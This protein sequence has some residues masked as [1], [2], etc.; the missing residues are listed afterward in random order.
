MS[1]V[2]GSNRIDSF[3]LS[4]S[5]FVINYVFHELTWGRLTCTVIMSYYIKN[6]IS[7]QADQ[8]CKG[9]MKENVSTNY[10][11]KETM[12]FTVS[13]EWLKK[14]MEECITK[15]I[16]D[17]QQQSTIQN[18]QKNRSNPSITTSNPT[19]VSSMG[20]TPTR[21]GSGTS[22]ST[23][24]LEG[25][26]VN[27]LHP[28]DMLLSWWMNTSGADIGM[29]PHH[30]RNKLT[31]LSECDAGNYSTPIPYTKDD[32]RTPHQIKE[33]IKRG[34]R[35][36]AS[37]STT[38]ETTSKLPEITTGYTFALGIDWEQHVSK[39]YWKTSKDDTKIVSSIN[40]DDNN[41]DNDDDNDSIEEDFHVPYFTE[42]DIAVIP[43]RMNSC[44]FFTAK[45]GR[46]VVDE[47]TTSTSSSNNRS[48]SNNKTKE[49][50]TRIGVFIHATRAIC[51]K[52]TDCGIID[53][54]PT[55]SKSAEIT[56]SPNGGVGGRRSSLIQFKDLDRLTKEFGD[57]I[58][59]E[60]NN[61]M[62]LGLGDEDG[63]DTDNADYNE[64]KKEEIKFKK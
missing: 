49:E 22:V 48:S 58:R 41:N 62:D 39:R 50:T 24:T 34:K 6:I 12:L 25:E 26:D 61:D 43:P 7:N 10:D 4:L 3:L 16:E 57:S 14:K 30:L 27:E 54:E 53:E 1:V 19:A 13:N 15:K 5:S 17:D 36:T 23:L 56:A 2:F 40:G 63:D 42:R 11:K 9:L 55:S 64:G 28:T 45:N 32:F 31:V 20:A 18:N 33:S 51:L 21:S 37:H 38:Y 44:L 52:I 29:I 35:Y 47:D 8:W 60:L 46:D 59:L